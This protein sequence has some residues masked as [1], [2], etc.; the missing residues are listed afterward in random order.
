MNKITSIIK[1]I[2]EEAGKFVDTAKDQVT[3]PDDRKS[4]EETQQ[5]V[6]G[7][8]KPAEAKSPDEIVKNKAKDKAKL[9]KTREKL[10]AH[11]EY[12]QKL[13]NPPKQKEEPVAEKVEREKMQDL[14][15]EEERQAK[16]PPPLAVRM[17]TQKTEKYPGASG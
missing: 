5:L 1:P 17:A 3:L 4:K 9:E 6:E 12:F 11:Q 2:V 16:K 8:Y 15:S 10:R 14:Q 13:V 7:I